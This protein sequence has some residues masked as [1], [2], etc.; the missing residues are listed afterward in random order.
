MKNIIKMC[1]SYGI[2]LSFRQKMVL[3]YSIAISWNIIP[4][5]LRIFHYWFLTAKSWL[6]CC[7]RTEKR[8][9]YILISGL[10]MEDLFTEKLRQADVIKILRA[11]LQFLN[12]Q[13]FTKLHV[14]LIPYIYHKIPSQEFDYALF[15]ANAKLVRRDS[16]SVIENANVIGFSR[17]RKQSANR[18][19]KNS[20]IIKEEPEFELFW[21]EILIPNID[22][23][24]GAKPVH[25]AAEIQSFIVN[26]PKI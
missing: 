6:L 20:L 26:F 16:L 17:H 14:K 22:N 24:H 23:K 1:F 3:F 2:I 18:G 9:K 8:M 15:C 5:V 12:V 25:T 11:L 21:N 7:L 19:I 10:H 13:G 4:T